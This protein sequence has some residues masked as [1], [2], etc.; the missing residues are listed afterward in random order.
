MPEWLT[1]LT[2][3]L[4][5]NPQ[6][7]GLSLFLVA[8]LECLAVVGLLMPGTVLVFAIA[9]L[10]GTGVLSL[11]E[12]LL[13][14]YAGGLLG[15][16][17][18]YGL[19]RRYHQNIRS[20][21]GLRNHPEWLTRAELY[22]E[23]YGIASL[24]VGRFI[25]PL[26]PMLPL[27]AGMLD[28]PF[29]RFLLV[30]LVA[31]AGWSMAYLLPGWTAG[32][33]VRLPLP[34]G[35]WGEAGVVIGVLLLLI[36]G[37]VHSSLHQLRWVTPFAAGLS[38]A[39]LIGLFIGWPYLVEFDEGL[40][41]VIQGERSP[42]FDRFMVVVTRA[43]DFHTQLWAAVLL[44]LLLIGMKQV[45]AAVF[46]ILTLLG[47]A[48]ANGALKETFGRIRPEVLLEPLDTFSFPSGHSSAAFAF[49]L[50]LGVLAGRGQPPR[51]R[52]AWVLL[53]GLPATAIALSR[54]YLGV[55]WPTDVI[56][57]AVLAATVC[58]ASLT[59]VQWRAPMDALS[60]KVW[61][62]ILPA[63]LGLIGA[64]ALWALPGAMQMYRYQ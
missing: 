40:M 41:T 37:I 20:L 54:V 10:A 56:A 9:V 27:T 15:D 51:L 8:C 34:D 18:S 28:M 32:A 43:G 33:A 14:G 57:G 25:G 11:G 42:I 48:M 30:S 19:G 6:W 38:A 36:G 49:F 16:L 44:S 63:T 1:A 50:T 13:L 12:T 60:P 31:A 3:W 26:R 46:A 4:A 21:R 24:L 29:G 61:W 2:S 62:L 64:F 55:H 53:A 59:L 52:L 17:L 45:R 5:E 47:T 22:V 7:L 23:R 39:I 35:F 58:A